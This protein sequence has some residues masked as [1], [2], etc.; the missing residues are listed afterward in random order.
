MRRT[1]GL[2]VAI[3]VVAS[4]ERAAGRVVE[5]VREGAHTGRAGDGK[6]VVLPVEDAV[7]IRT[8]GPGAQ[9]V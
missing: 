7:R 5:A 2:R 4:G 3:M 1:A 6:I 8:G 9:A